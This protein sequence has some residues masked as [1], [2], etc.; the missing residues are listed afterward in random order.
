MW[1]NNTHASCQTQFPQF[2]L[3]VKS[4]LK[5][6]GSSLFSETPIRNLVITLRLVAFNF[7][8]TLRYVK[9]SFPYTHYAS[10]FL[11]NRFHSQKKINA[12][13]FPFHW[14]REK[15]N[16]VRCYRNYC[17]F[18]FQ[19]RFKFLISACPTYPSNAISVKI[20]TLYLTCQ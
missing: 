20:F 2:R 6:A 16:I 9:A 5:T 12:I 14:G 1:N 19:Y 18:F 15:D 11:K 10:F 3:I 7:N 4:G 13:S 8:R 17:Y